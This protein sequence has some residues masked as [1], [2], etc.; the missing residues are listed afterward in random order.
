MMSEESELLL[1]ENR[2]THDGADT[3]GAD[4]ANLLASSG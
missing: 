3:G 1:D 4:K 2:L